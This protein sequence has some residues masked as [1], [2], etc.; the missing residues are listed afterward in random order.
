MKHDLSR[1]PDIIARHRQHPESL[2]MILQDIQREFHYL[3][4]EALTQTAEALDVPLSKVFSVSTFYNAF[5]LTPRG[6]K[7]I[8]V[9]VGTACHI[10]GAKLIQ[11]Q[12]EN[13]LKIKAGE[14]TKDM[15]FTIE[16]VG[17][18][19]AC[20]MAPVVMVNDKY[21]GGCNVNSV[22]KLTRRKKHAN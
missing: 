2:I 1:I 11:E 14:T 13:T 18:V 10:R 5:S 12:F 6:E 3:P 17:C 8:R 21:H 4:T 19:G 9:C 22:K 7:L 16:V 20:A 15:D